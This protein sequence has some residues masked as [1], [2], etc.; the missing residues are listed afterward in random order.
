MRSLQ[1]RLL[2]GVGLLVVVAVALVALA[3]RRDTRREFLRYQDVERRASF[4]GL[5]AQA[6]AAAARLD[7]ACCAADVMLPVAQ[8]IPARVWLLVLDEA[9]ERVVAIAGAPATAG[10]PD[11][12]LRLESARARDGVLAVEASRSVDGQ[13]EQIELRIQAQGESIRLASGQ[14]GWVYLMPLPDPARTAR[15]DAF[16]GTLDRRLLWLT[17]GIGALAL[18][19][20]W[21]LARR[22]VKPLAD[23]RDAAAA[24]GAGAFDHRVRVQG[25]TE[26]ASLASSVN[27]LAERLEEQQALRQALTNDVAHEL[28]TPLTALRCRLESVIDGVAQDP[29]QVCRA[30][31]D[32]VLHLSRL[33]DDLQDVALAEAR[34]LRLSRTSVSL[35]A[36]VLDARSI[37]GLHDDARFAVEMAHDLAVDADPARLRQ[38]L[39][40][41]LDNARRHGGPDARVTVAARPEGSDVV[42]E[43]TNT[44]RHLEPGE[45]ARIFDRFYRADPSRQRQTGGTGLGLAI[46]K[47][48]VEAHGG[49]VWAHSANDVVVVGVAWPAA[50]S[51]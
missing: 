39:V 49:R 10:T 23:L 15:V 38:V 33:V 32:D 7:G 27:A 40:N 25:P 9:R 28:R 24:L 44:G 16:L 17:V 22:T 1:A 8:G 13:V 21:L 19:A 5:P 6:R 14:R 18:L 4:D 42:L 51:S 45:I 30:V 50:R 41:L 36:A 43:I 26:V 34:E 29:A 3:L 12:S 35:P 20:T 37:V 11:D 31:R 2:V 47:H 46:V 48:L